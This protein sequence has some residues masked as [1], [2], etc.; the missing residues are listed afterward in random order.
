MWILEEGA[1]PG[2]QGHKHQ[3]MPS[4]FCQAPWPAMAGNSKPRRG[5]NHHLPISHLPVGKGSQDLRKATVPGEH[6]YEHHG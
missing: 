4:R 2:D 3:G 5:R 6:V 1:D